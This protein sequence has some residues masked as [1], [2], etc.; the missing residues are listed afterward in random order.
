MEV[1]KKQDKPLGKDW[2]KIAK[3]FSSC[4]VVISIL[5]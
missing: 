1:K 3:I 4:I 5:N 2:D